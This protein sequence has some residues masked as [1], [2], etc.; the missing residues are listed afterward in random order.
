MPSRFTVIFAIVLIEALMFAAPSHAGDTI[1]QKPIRWLFHGP[2][3]AAIAADDAVARILD[4]TQPFVMKGRNI[5][6]APSRWNAI[7]FASFTSFRA[8]R[9]ALAQGTL[10]PDVK[11]I[12]YDNEK[13]QFTPSVEQEN[14]E[15]YERLAADLVHSRGLLFI[16]APAVN[17]VAVL[18]PE[19]PDKR[20]DTYLRLGIAAEAARYA[21]V[22]DIQAQGSERNTKLY[23]NFVSQAAAQAREANPKVQVFAG[24][25]TNPSGQQVTAEDILRAIA[26]T[27]DN[28]DGYWLNIPQPSEYCPRCNGFRP[29]IAVEVLRRLAKP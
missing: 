2:G 20:Y 27:R 9:N 5:D 28:V 17:L 10:A 8:M 24:I 18:A 14:P 23:A 4:D 6:A 16:S 22:V 26:A 25:S 11:G 21:D 15:R 3:I 7:P 13:W 29:D 19:S 12:M 1:M